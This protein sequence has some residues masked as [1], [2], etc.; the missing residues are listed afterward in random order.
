MFFIGLSAEVQKVY[1]RYVKLL[2][3]T[4]YFPQKMQFPVGANFLLIL[5]TAHTTFIGFY[6]LC[7]RKERNNT[8]NNVWHLWHRIVE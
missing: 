7:V 3:V 6:K 1:L 5:F 2:T 4:V 8:N